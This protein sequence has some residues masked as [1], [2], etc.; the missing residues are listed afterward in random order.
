MPCL[1]EAVEEPMVA[2]DPIL[3]II[4]LDLAFGGLR[5]IESLCMNVKRGSRTG[6]IGPNGAGKTT[7]FNL[8]SGVYSP[9][10]GSIILNG[11][12][13]GDVPVAKRVHLG[14]GRTFQNLRL[15]AHLTVLENVMLGQHH[16]ASTAAMFVPLVSR[17]NRTAVNEALR[18]IDT[19]GLEKDANRLAEGLTFGMQKRVELA[20][21]LV[22]KPKLL[23]LDEPASGLNT[24]ERSE[25][26]S[27][28]K[29]AIDL[30]VTILL[31]EHDLNFIAG[32]CDHVVALHFGRKIAEGT[33]EEIKN[34]KAVTGA[35]LGAGRRARE[36]SH[37]A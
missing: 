26:L 31:I 24:A 10:H 8:L 4:D 37:A 21:A 35:Y 15:M 3:K 23:L 2:D 12:D 7:L 20:R 6:I 28:L 14:I 1:V 25:L 27:A 18:A 5:V 22:T 34:N 19:V 29:S 33:F 16:R 30:D 17:F 11:R 32:I 9:A 36:A 13:I